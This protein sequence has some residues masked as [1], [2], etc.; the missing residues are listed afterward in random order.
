MSK[1]RF[2]T[3]LLSF[4]LL[5]IN[6]AIFFA[7][8]LGVD[9]NIVTVLLSLLMS[10]LLLGLYIFTEYRPVRLVYGGVPIFLFFGFSVVIPLVVS[11]VVNS[12]IEYAA[13]TFRTVAYFMFLYVVWAL[14]KEG[15][16][17]FSGLYNVVSILVLFCA[18]IG[19]LQIASGNLV[20]M[21]GA[22]RLSSIYGKTPAGFALLMLLVSSFY[23]G[24]FLSRRI[25]RRRFQSFMF[26]CGATI[27]MFMTH[28]RQALAT[29]FLLIFF[30]MWL[31]SGKLMR[32]VVILLLVLV[33]Y[34]LFWVVVNTEMAPRIALL[35]DRGLSDGSSQTRLAIIQNSLAA[36]Y[37]ME[38][39][40]G[41]GLGGFNHFYAG[42]SGELGVAAHN[43][44]L[45]FYVE[46]GVLS[47]FN[48]VLITFFGLFYFLRKAAQDDIFYVPLSVYISISFLSFLNNPLYYAQTQV[49][50]FSIYGYFLSLKNKSKSVF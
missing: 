46:G 10:F 5:V 14:S 32:V 11:V 2:Y 1:N 9:R 4:S 23:W 26:F 16:F 27:M 42:V 28:S 17:N 38:K 20:D 29:L 31:R 45:L 48:F 49:L 7:D 41:V 30:L 37:G 40:V 34:G 25:E 15:Y 35:F 13:T 44:Y 6:V 22:N 12:P 47:L 8:A 3:F 33:S 18:V 19:G 50:A 21:N 39:I 43:D 24:C 36:L